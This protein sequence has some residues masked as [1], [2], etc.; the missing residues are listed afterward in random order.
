MIQLNHFDCWVQ[1]TT[2]QAFYD[3]GFFMLLASEKNQSHHL[4]CPFSPQGECG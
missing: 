1:L 4:H 2:N 3:L